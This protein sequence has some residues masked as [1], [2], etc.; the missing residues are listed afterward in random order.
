MS[1][2]TK[3][4]AHG[5]DRVVGPVEASYDR[6]VRRTS[7]MLGLLL[8]LALMA[9]LIAITN[10]EPMPGAWFVAGLALAT[11]LAV[12]PARIVVGALRDAAAEQD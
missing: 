9:W 1:T 8:G 2:P 11:A 3:V 6:W 5:R 10:Y 7:W 12:L 4:D